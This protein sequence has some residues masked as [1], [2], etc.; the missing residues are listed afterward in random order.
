MNTSDH[1]C[2]CSVF[3]IDTSTEWAG[4]ALL[5]E[6]GVV[7]QHTWHAGQNH[8]VEIFTELDRLLATSGARDQ[9]TALGVATGPGS[10]NG[11]R[12]AVT[13]A[14]TLAF[15]WHLP[16]V[17]IPTLDGIAQ[18]AAM[19]VESD[20]PD[21]MLALMEA[22]RDELYTCWYDLIDPV[23]SER[24]MADQVAQTRSIQ[25]RGAIMI[26]PVADIITSAPAGT[27]LA[28]GV[29]TQAHQEALAAGLGARLRL[30]RDPDDLPARVVGI[31]QRALARLA[32][33]ER[34]DVLAL[35]PTYVRRPTITTSTRHPAPLPGS[36][37]S[38]L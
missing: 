32:A 8:S 25:P 6:A 14:K 10:F 13:V 17:G 33:G 5:A 27:I 19:Q 26:M 30:R 2:P 16:L 12:V 36:S 31:G 4:L 35:E 28:A 1:R 3:A 11:T 34:D 20:P 7:A 18:A 29:L 22:G 23:Q 9:I 37:D 21:T 15:V 24:P 38:A